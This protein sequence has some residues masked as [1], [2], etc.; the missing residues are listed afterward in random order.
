MA[1]MAVSFYPSL[2]PC[3]LS[4]GGIKRAATAIQF[5]NKQKLAWEEENERK[6]EHQFLQQIEHDL[7]K[8]T[9]KYYC[10]GILLQR[11]S[12][13]FDC[14]IL[15]YLPPQVFWGYGS[16]DSNSYYLEF[17]YKLMGRKS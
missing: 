6:Q 13:K 2:S 9:F 14:S 11:I 15:Q 1:V 5:S 12:E 10:Y 17:I 3:L 8:S 7:C 4:F 16:A